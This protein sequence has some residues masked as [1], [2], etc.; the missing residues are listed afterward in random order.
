MT[1]DKQRKNTKPNPEIK[2]LTVGRSDWHIDIHAI[3][4]TQSEI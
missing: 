1:R 2:I 4:E 3:L